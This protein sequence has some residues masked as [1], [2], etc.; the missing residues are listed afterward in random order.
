MEKVVEQLK[1]NSE[2]YCKEYRQREGS[3]YIQD[4]VEIVRN[5]SKEYEIKTNA[6]SIRAITDEQLAEYWPCPYDTA[7]S[8]IMP[9]MLDDDV[10]GSPT[11]EY[12]GKCMMK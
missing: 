11:K 12:C 6:D 7:G 10:M 5:G 4:V 8:N 3:L 1:E 2:V 9:C